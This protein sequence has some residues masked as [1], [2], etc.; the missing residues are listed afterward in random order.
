[1]CRLTVA[2]SSDVC[3][4]CDVCLISSSIERFMVI[5]RHFHNDGTWQIVSQ[6]FVQNSE[7]G[8]HRKKSPGFLYRIENGR[9]RKIIWL[10]VQN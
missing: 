3:D 4:V 9:H 1:M 6:I 7:N 10:F 8:Q 5:D 2:G